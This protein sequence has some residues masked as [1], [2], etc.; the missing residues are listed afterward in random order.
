[1]NIKEYRINIAAKTVGGLDLDA[2]WYLTILA[3]SKENDLHRIV[4]QT[5]IDGGSPPGPYPVESH[6]EN[7]PDGIKS[8]PYNPA[9][10]NAKSEN[11]VIKNGFEA[12]LDAWFGNENWEAV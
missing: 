6:Y 10:D 9:T 12:D 11:V 3:V 5:C 1:M 8:Y 2:G 7:T 4:V